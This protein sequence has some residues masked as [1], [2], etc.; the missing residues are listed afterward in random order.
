MTHRLIRRR[1]EVVTASTDTLQ[2]VADVLEEGGLAAIA[3]GHPRRAIYALLARADDRE[4]TLR[5]NR[6][7]GRPPQ[8]VL[9]VAG[10]TAVAEQ[11]AD[12]SATGAQGQLAA[13]RDLSTQELLTG[14]F[15][16]G[17]VALM[18]EA[19]ASLPPSIVKID[20][21]GVARVLVVG[22]SPELDPGNFYDQLIDQLATRR[23]VLVAGTSGNRSGLRTYTTRDH[24]AAQADLGA[25]IDVF[26][27]PQL[28]IPRLRR[29]DAPVSCSAF[30][31]TGSEPMLIRHGSLHPDNFRPVLHRYHVSPAS[32]RIGGRQRKA[33]AMVERWQRTRRARRTNP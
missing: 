9:A 33:A 13:S 12:L 5:L 4:A 22:E 31:L 21:S 26:V 23:G 6:L 11:V 32:Q 27:R 10:A 7:K 18:L 1:L 28:P 14:M 16:T 3:W 24:V 2:P 15:D 25:D 30:D 17:P 29:W 8:Q 20:G 19:R